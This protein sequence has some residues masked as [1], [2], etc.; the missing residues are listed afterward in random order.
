[1]QLG[2]QLGKG[3]CPCVASQVLQRNLASSHVLHSAVAGHPP[4]SEP[5][6]PSTHCP[7]AVSKVAFAAGGTLPQAVLH[8]RLA[9]RGCLQLT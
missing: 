3:V 2:P 8:H 6:R 4:N 7:P 5:D 9:V 1:M